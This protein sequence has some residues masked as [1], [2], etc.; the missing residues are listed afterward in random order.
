M[1]V[2]AND[3]G[4]DGESN[5][6]GNDATAAADGSNANDNDGGDSRKAIGQG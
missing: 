2:Y 4:N 5:G 6:D 1:T 3:D